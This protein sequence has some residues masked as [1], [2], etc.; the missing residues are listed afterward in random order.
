MEP[1][2]P[3]GR[4]VL[5]RVLRQVAD[6]TVVGIELAGLSAPA[7]QDRRTDRDDPRLR[8]AVRMNQ[9]GNALLWEGEQ[10]ASRRRR[11]ELYEELYVTPEVRQILNHL[12]AFIF[13]GDMRAGSLPTEPF[14]V[15]FEEGTPQVVIDEIRR[16]IAAMRLSSE[17]PRQVHEGLLKGDC[18]AEVV[19][20]LTRVV[21]MRAHVASRVDVR[22][23]A[24]GSIVG[25]AIKPTGGD[26]VGAA[27][28]LSPVQVVHYA[29]HRRWGHLY[30]ESIFYGMPAI[31]RQYTAAIDVLHTLLV[32]AATSRRTVGMEVPDGWTQEQISN[33][34]KD[35]RGMNADESF[36]TRD[37]VMQRKIGTMLD[38]TD[39]VWPYRSG[40]GAPTFH[41]ETP[42]PLDK[43]IDV[44]R[45]DQSRLYVGA[46]FPKALAGILEDAAGL[47]GGSALTVADLALARIIRF[48]QADVADL[49]LQ[50]IVRAAL[51]A[52]IPITA[53]TLLVKMPTLGSFNEKLAAE[54]EKLRAETAVALG[55]IQ[56][57]MRWILGEV[58][59]VPAEDIEDLLLQMQMEPS[60][61]TGALPGAME[62]ERIREQFAEQ[63]ERLSEAVKLAMPVTR[64]LSDPALRK[65]L[66]DLGRGTP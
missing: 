27:V 20:S 57:P 56:V 25:Y 49:V 26:S 66:E 48:H 47:G 3:I 35:I 31:G 46:G 28:A 43:L 41:T 42:A 65:I 18:F 44:A 58:L 62:A 40:T 63:V 36:F 34:I 1:S 13:G 61:S 9:L 50:Y 39:K 54:T 10:D 7:A 15:E 17:I 64:E 6:P 59:S 16:A 45:F 11:Y 37:G 8:R 30:G 55:S 4:R 24:Y 53:D 32:L 14:S 60:P 21:D 22:T 5:Q 51:I 38:Y 12:L 23:D 19:H 52:S 2:S 29:P 33:W